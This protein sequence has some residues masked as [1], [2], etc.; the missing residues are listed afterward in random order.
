[1]GGTGEFE[2]IKLHEETIK[3]HSSLLSSL[4]ERELEINARIL[5]VRKET[6]KQV[7]EAQEEAETIKKNAVE[8]GKKQGQHI[9]EREINKTKQEA[10][11]LK[12]SLKEKKN[13]LR[14]TYLKNFDRAVNQV[15]EMVLQ[16]TPESE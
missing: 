3:G 11:K 14:D 13:H 15:K 12:K 8:E 4:K 10:E 1:M 16:K 6:E 7:K 9:F 2:K 5:E